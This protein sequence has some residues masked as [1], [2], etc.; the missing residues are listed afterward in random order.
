MIDAWLRGS[1]NF[2]LRSFGCEPLLVLAARGDSSVTSRRLT[3]GSRRLR[4]TDDYRHDVANAT[5]GRRRRWRSAV[6]FR[7]FAPR[8]PDD[9]TAGDRLAVASVAEV[10]RPVPPERPQRRLVLPAV[11]PARVR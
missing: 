1:A 10:R 2:E 7:V 8:R 11:L 4:L 3:T 6:R 5:A 9:G